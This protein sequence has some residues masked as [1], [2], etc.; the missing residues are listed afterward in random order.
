MSARKAVYKVIFLNHGK[1]YELYARQLSA[2]SL[3]GFIEVGELQFDSVGVV[4]DPV[5]ERLRE[6]FGNTRVLHL[7][8]HSVVRVEEVSSKGT[9]RIRDA[10]GE[11]VIP[12]VPAR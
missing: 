5:E 6:E 12:F 1:S 11:K 8:M 4:L 3:P 9:A 7:P 10:S 2:S